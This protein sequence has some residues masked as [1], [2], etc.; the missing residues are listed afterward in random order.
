MPENRPSMAEDIDPGTGTGA[1]HDPF[2]LACISLAPVLNSAAAVG[3]SSEL[4]A[5]RGRPLQVDA[6]E[7]RQIGGLCLQVLLSAGKTW[8]ADNVTFALT[9]VSAALRDQASLYGADLFSDSAG[10]EA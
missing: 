4:L 1:G 9:P 6:G 5:A 8:A 2:G 10:A 3:L 7:V